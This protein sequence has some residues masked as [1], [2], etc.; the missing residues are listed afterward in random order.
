MN[1]VIKN[2][3]HKGDFQFNDSHIQFFERGTAEYEGQH[4]SNVYLDNEFIHQAADFN[5]IR[6]FFIARTGVGKSAI[7]EHIK[8]KNESKFVIQIDPESFIPQLLQSGNYL[9]ILQK[10]GISIEYF[11]KTLWRFIIVAELLRRRHGADKRRW[12]DK[13]FS[14]DE[15]GDRARKFLDRHKM[16]MSDVS[17]GERILS[18]I[19]D[20]KIKIEAIGIKFDFGSIDQS[21]KQA[22]RDAIRE[23]EFSEINT[24]VK[25]LDDLISG[26]SYY[27]LIDDLD[28]AIVDSSLGVE[29]IKSLFLALVD[30]ANLKQVKVVVSLRTNLFAQ[31]KFN[32]P[33]KLRAF[34]SHM[35][36][37]D[38]D[39]KRMLDRRFG[40][41]FDVDTNYIWSN[42]FPTEIHFD[43]ER[44]SIH[45]Y[46]MRMSN[47]R[48]R[49]LFLFVAS[50]MKYVKGKS[51]ISQEAFKK[52][53]EEFSQDRLINFIAEWDSPFCG[54]AE[55][56]SYFQGVDPVMSGKDLR[57]IIDSMIIHAEVDTKFRWLY[58]GEY[59]KNDEK[60]YGDPNGLFLLLFRVGVIGFRDISGKLRFC[61]DY[62]T[63]PNS[64]NLRDDTAIFVNPA[65]AHALTKTN[66]IYRQAP[67]VEVEESRLS[68]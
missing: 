8:A 64:L 54:L 35:S 45:K 18:Y 13:V 52:C 61:F 58:E 51:R 12:I 29:L 49:D 65:F 20:L 40:Y 25:Q 15:V 2:K 55:L 5:S 14:K 39:L 62:E 44:I 28:K 42:I 37:S 33:E 26:E 56:L 24:L 21:K 50:A 57:K 3:K 53:E 46:L 41:L 31:I 10:N 6:T 19:S 17:F 67:D 63:A 11:L 32:Q 43:R 48:P 16:L 1:K 60:N 66:A 34:I 68:D 30:I 23:F 38:N 36:W 7:I 27:I 59:I 4:L 47:R 22:V 9:E